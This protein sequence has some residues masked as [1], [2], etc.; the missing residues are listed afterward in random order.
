MGSGVRFWRLSV[1]KVATVAE[2]RPVF[3]MYVD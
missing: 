2:N 1:M 3:N